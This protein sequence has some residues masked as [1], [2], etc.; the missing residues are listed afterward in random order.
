M[1]RHAACTKVQLTPSLLPLTRDDVT[2]QENV[3][4]SSRRAHEYDCPTYRL[5]PD[6]RSAQR[7]HG[8][9][10]YVS[11]VVGSEGLVEDAPQSATG[12]TVAES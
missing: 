11:G 5:Q 6:A 4:I 9:L 2:V 12:T 1:T 3:L 10:R 8:S 7:G